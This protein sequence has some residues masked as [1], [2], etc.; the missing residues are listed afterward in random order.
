MLF[1]STNSYNTGIVNGETTVNTGG[2]LGTSHYDINVSKCYNVSSISGNFNVGGIVGG[3]SRTNINSCYNTNT[4]SGN[5]NVGGIIGWLAPFND[6]DNTNNLIWYCYNIGNIVGQESIGT[7]GGY[8]KYYGADYIY[9]LIG[10]SLNL[11]GIYQN[12][13][14]DGSHWGLLTKNELTSIVLENYGNNFKADTL[15]K[16]NGYPILNWQN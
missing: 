7:I 8:I 10:T 1:R 12:Y 5:Y 16:N 14:G 11:H 6:K 2:I 9:G 3:G 13:K 15:N 4:I